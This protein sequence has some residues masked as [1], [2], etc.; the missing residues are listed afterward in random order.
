M[1]SS[2]YMYVIELG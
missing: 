1:Y 2:W